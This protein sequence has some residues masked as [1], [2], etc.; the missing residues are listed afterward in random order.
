MFEGHGLSATRIK[1]KTNMIQMTGNDT[2]YIQIDDEQWGNE[3]RNN[4][5]LQGVDQ[6]DGEPFGIEKRETEGCGSDDESATVGSGRSVQV[7]RW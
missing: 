2:G 1:N 7:W 4:V 3:T 6:Y 5:Q